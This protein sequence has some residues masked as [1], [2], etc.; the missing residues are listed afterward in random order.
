MVLKQ[1]AKLLGDKTTDNVSRYERGMT[2]SLKNALKL[3]IIYNIPIQVLLDGYY[4]SC[5]R[6]IK[7][8]ATQGIDADWHDGEEHDF[9]TLE[10]KLES[11]RHPD[12]LVLDAARSHTAKLIRLRGER[13]DHI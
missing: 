2:P 8:E 11:N 4:E 1:V 13:M 5:L 9:C 10:E 6:E 3:G 7:R 12:G